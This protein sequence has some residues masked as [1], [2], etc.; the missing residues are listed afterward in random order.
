M[1]AGPVDQT[2]RK[3]VTPP[4]PHCVTSNNGSGKC[5][6]RVL[7]QVTAGHTSAQFLFLC[8]VLFLIGKSLDGDNI[9]EL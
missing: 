7:L 6:S 2:L 9:G 8:F 3:H 4:L 5:R 1:W